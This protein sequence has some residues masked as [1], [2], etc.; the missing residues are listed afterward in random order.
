MTERG[1]GGTI[2]A[3]AVPGKAL[4]DPSF[5]A[6]LSKPVGSNMSYAHTPPTGARRAQWMNTFSTTEACVF[7]R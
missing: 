6:D 1:F 3:A 4:W 2:S 5:A 7:Q